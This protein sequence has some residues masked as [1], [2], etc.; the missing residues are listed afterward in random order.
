MKVKRLIPV[1]LSL[2]MVG[3]LFAGCSDKPETPDDNPGNTQEPGGDQGG[4]T[5]NPGGDQN[6]GGNQN[7]GGDQGGEQLTENSPL[8]DGN[9]I[10]VVGDSTVCEYVDRTD[11]EKPEPE[12]KYY[13]PRYGYGTQLSQYLNCTESQVVNLA[14]SGRSSKSFLTEANYTT[15][16][17]NIAEGD[18]LIIGFGHNDEK[19]DSPDRYTTAKDTDTYT[20]DGSF[21]K[22]LYDNYVKMATDKGATP[23]LCTPIVRYSSSGTYS[24]AKIHDT[25]VGDYSAAIR[26][27]GEATGTAVVDLTTI[28]KTI[29]EADNAA[30]AYFH[31]HPGYEGDIK[32]PPY[33][34]T[35]V[36]SGR[37]DT[38]I[39]KY[40]AK[41]VCY[42]FAN[43]LKDTDCNLKYH[44]KKDITAPT[45]E[46]DYLDAIWQKFVKKP[47]TVFDTTDPDNAQHN[48]TGEWY[49]SCMGNIGG[50]D[51]TPFTITNTGDN[52]FSI[53][54]TKGKGKIASGEDGFASVFRQIPIGKDFEASA[55]ATVK[56]MG[57]VKQAAFGMML[58]DDIYINK[59]SKKDA[60][61]LKSNYVAAGALTNE[62]ADTTAIFSRKSTT[63]NKSK[64]TVTLAAEQQIEIS[65]KKVGQEVTLKFGDVTEKFT[66]FDFRSTDT[67]YMYLCLFATRD[68]A[69]DFTNVQ[70]EITGDSQ[71]A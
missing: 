16:T 29:Y 49:K 20:T 2:L 27:L 68:F 40:G 48:L 7:P 36:P 46:V 70:F 11:P 9:K 67:D 1:V 64:N 15:L 58:R 45:K 41:M 12:D 39:N 69:V 42:Q 6:P 5:Q 3:T 59:T 65:I 18:Y 22:T 35:E 44:I 38:H 32:N 17:T 24:G 4:N 10:Y 14:L 66:D 51:L 13:L 21:Q 61:T 63:L 28:T 47:Y 50:D 37:D 31:A 34:G 52:A 57:G 53:T 60:L 55:I 26:K 71:G 62:D 33:D 19:S 25:D 54:C 30:A 8:P 56:T 43:A 23:I